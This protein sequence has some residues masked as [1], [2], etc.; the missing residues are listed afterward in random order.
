MVLLAVNGENLVIFKFEHSR[1]QKVSF[2]GIHIMGVWVEDKKDLH[3]FS[4]DF[5]MKF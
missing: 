1:R 4:W 5:L 2:F 3:I